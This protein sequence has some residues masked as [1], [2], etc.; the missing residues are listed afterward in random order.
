MTL[1]SQCPSCSKI[2]NLKSKTA[3]G[4]RVAC[5]KCKKPF[6]VEPYEEEEYYED[7]D[8]GYDSYEDDYDDGYEEEE[9]APRRG[10]ESSGGKGRG[11]EASAGRGTKGRGGKSSAKGGGK[12]SRGRKQG[13]MPAWAKGLLAGGGGVLVLALLVWGIMSL[14]GGGGVGGGTANGMNFAYLPDNADAYGYVKP[15]EFWNSAF[16]TSIR[17][18]PTTAQQ[19][20][21]VKSQMPLQVPVDVNDIEVVHFAVR[22]V[23]PGMWGSGPGIVGVAKMKKDIDLSTLQ[24]TAQTHAGKSYFTDTAGRFAAWKVDSTTYVLGEVAEVKAAIDRGSVPA[25]GTERFSFASVGNQ[26]LLVM[27][28]SKNIPQQPVNGLPTATGGYIG[29]TA[30]SGLDF[31]GGGQ[32]ANSADVK[33]ASDFV[34]PVLTKIKARMAAP[35][36]QA[37]IPIESVKI[38]LNTVV[39]SLKFE[40]NG[41]TYQM[42]MTI[43]GSLMSAIKDAQANPLALLGLAGVLQEFAKELPMPGMMPPGSGMPSNGSTFPNQ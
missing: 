29:L 8:D 39:N 14:V 25:K 13:G 11:R 7:E 4:K 12:K 23:N 27:I 43:P 34:Q 37:A 20:E 1:Q 42:S 40:E 32:Y 38:T 36:V 18:D 24:M 35:D 21:A 26:Q 31:V 28:D 3:F 30:N 16:I 5:P 17:N 33:K 9:A 15:A 2:L 6:V 19:L 10:R 41:N 22:S